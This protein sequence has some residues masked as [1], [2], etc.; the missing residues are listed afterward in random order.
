M[1]QTLPLVQPHPQSRR[2]VEPAD[3]LQ[4]NSGVQ[5][6]YSSVSKLAVSEERK[7]VVPAKRIHKPATVPRPKAEPVDETRPV[8]LVFIESAPF[9]YLA[10]QKDVEIFL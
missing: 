3:I 4:S 6:A 1:L 5:P 8:N 9:M 2:G 7:Y 10:K